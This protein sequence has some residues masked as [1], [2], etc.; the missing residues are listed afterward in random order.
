[1][2]AQNDEKKEDWFEEKSDAPNV[3]DESHEFCSDL[4]EVLRV[5]AD[6]K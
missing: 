3:D 2:D 1:L 6:E 4:F 5:Q